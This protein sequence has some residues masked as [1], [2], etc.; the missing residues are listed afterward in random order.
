[1]S[2]PTKKTKEEQAEMVCKPHPPG[3]GLLPHAG[4]VAGQSPPGPFGSAGTTGLAAVGAAAAAAAGCT[5]AVAPAAALAPPAP[6]TL[7]L[8]A[9]TAAAALPVQISYSPTGNT[10]VLA[11]TTAQG[12]KLCFC[13]VREQGNTDSKEGN[14]NS[15]NNDHSDTTNHAK[16]SN[17][18]NNKQ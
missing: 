2:F 5:P 10:A 11:M 16:T 12:T 6:Y 9:L 8:P 3:P 14:N 1:M 18:N 17:S 15:N 13:F 4:A 7:L